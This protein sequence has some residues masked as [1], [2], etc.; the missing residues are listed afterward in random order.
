MQ[1]CVQSVRA[2][3]GGQGEKWG[4]P[5]PPGGRPCSRAA[6]HAVTSADLQGQGEAPDTC[7]S[8]RSVVGQ[9]ILWEFQVRTRDG[10]TAHLN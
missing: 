2:D 3:L 8:P 1:H 10:K 4:H 9:A 7:Q 6:R 5:S